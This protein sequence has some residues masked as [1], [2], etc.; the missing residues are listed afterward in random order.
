MIRHLDNVALLIGR[1]AMAALFLPAGL[2]KIAGFSGFAAML[3]GKG[4]PLPELAAAAAIALEIVA[5]IALILGVFPRLTALA[6]IAFTVAAT[7]ISHSFW[8]FPDEARQAQQSAF[9]KNLA[10]TGGL[11]FYF[12]AGAGSWSWSGFRR[13]KAQTHAR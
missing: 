3:A 11:F 10:I 5:P 6:L 8:L 1:L 4:V 2:G 12:V 7:L 9:F 13:D